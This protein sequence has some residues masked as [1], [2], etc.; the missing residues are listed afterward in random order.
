MTER[1]CLDGMQQRS[2]TLRMH[3][4]QPIAKALLQYFGRAHGVAASGFVTREK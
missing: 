4:L 3:S 2:G 1:L